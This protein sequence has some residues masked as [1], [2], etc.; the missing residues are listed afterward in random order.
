VREALSREL[1]YHLEMLTRRY[2]AEG[3]DRVT[4]RA[5][6]LARMGDLDE[7]RRQC[8]AIVETTETHMRRADWWQGLWQ[9]IVYTARTARKAPLFTITAL[10]TIAI[11]IGASTAIFS[12]VNTVLIRGVAYDGADRLVAVWNSYAEEG[13]SEAA[14]SAAEFADYRERNHAF[15]GLAAVRPQASSLGGDCTG[16]GACEPERVNAYLVSPNL[17][18]VLKVMPVIGHPFTESDGAAGADPVVMLSDRVWRSRFGADSSVVGRSIL[19]GSAARTV[20]GVMPRDVR[21]PDAPIGFL[22]NTADVWLP[23][24]WTRNRADSRGNQNLAVIGRIGRDATMAAAQ[25]DLDAIANSFRAEFPDRYARAGL[26]WRIKAVPLREQV[27]GDVRASVL[28]LSAAVG[29]LL[30]IA[31]ANV[32]N[33]MLTRGSARRRELAV[34]S[35]LG[36]SRARL[37]RQLLVDAGVY[38][39]AGGGLGVLLAVAGVR[40]LVALAPGHIPFIDRTSVDV[41]V[42]GVAGLV[43]LVTAAL[44][45]GTPAWRFSIADPQLALAD[46]GRTAGA[47]PSRRRLRQVLIVA[48]IT[49]AVVVLVAAGLLGRSLAA[50]SRVAL[51]FDPANTTVAQVA[52]P[53]AR[54]DTRDK[55]LAFERNL[56]DRLAALPGVEHASAVYPLPMSGE[57]WSGTVIVRGRPADG[58]EPEPHAELSVAL[59]R[60]F[61]TMSIR[62]IQGR[63][64]GPAD[65]PG[66]PPV[67]IVDDEF[68]RR[69]WPGESAVGKHIG[70]GGPPKDDNSWTTV[71]G[72]VAHVRRASPKSDGEPQI[73]LAAL[74]RAEPTLYYVARANAGASP[75]PAAMRAALRE[76][77]RALPVSMLA[78]MRDLVSRTVARDRFNTLLLTIFGGVALVLA[79]VGLYG[80]MAF[81]VAQRVPEIAIRIALGATPG[82]VRR[83]VVAEGLGLALT[84]VVLGLACA[85]FFSRALGVLLFG[86][87]ATDPATYLAIAAILLATA[88]V[89]SYLPARRTLRIDPIQSLAR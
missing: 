22:K 66:A 74:Q 53:R 23:F 18:D 51:G 64:F 36:A 8:R 60:Y 88:G 52:L 44:I 89:A 49:M 25:S 86:I 56:T 77:D 48:E 27:L 80:V 7:V 67:A 40:A 31:C 42:L 6:A 2:E 57:G 4:A 85:L 26:Q 20:I 13:L 54:F 69:Y 14:I 21:F 78:T 62:T 76:E 59:P 65:G 35:A 15:D 29:L 71:V 73:Y 28:L 83:A 33:L 38:A 70:P 41:T 79:T 10:L 16:G 30:L 1:E 55:I 82:R 50:M 11:G 24:D 81:L 45:G 39:L 19:V 72:V 32:A 17:F 46:G 5:R 47:V 61:Q 84:G 34:R 68:A 43:T 63:D 87:E 75:L 37:V 58:P 3:L 12:V 9:D